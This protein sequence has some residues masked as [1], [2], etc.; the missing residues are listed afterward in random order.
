[1]T[2]TGDAA[3]HGVRLVDI[4]PAAV[5]LAGLSSA[6]RARIVRGNAVWRIGTLE[7]SE[8]R[9]VRGSVRIKAGTPGRKRNWVVATAI[10]APLSADHADTRVRARALPIFTG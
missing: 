7:P 2:N 3:A 4:P 8:S 9:T 6:Q 5:E 1:M 10:D